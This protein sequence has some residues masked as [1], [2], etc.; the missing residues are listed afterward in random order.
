MQ[1]PVR[2]AQQLP[3]QENQVGL[4]CA[5]NV[6]GLGWL[7]DH[8]HRARGHFRFLAHA[9][10][11][12]G[13]VARAGRDLGIAG[14]AARRHIDQIHAKHT[15]ASGQLDGFVRVPA[16]FHPVGG[17]HPHE[18]W[19]LLRPDCTNRFDHLQ[20]QADAVLE[21]TA[22]FIL[23][24]IAQRRQELVQQVTV[25]GVHLDHFEARLQ[26]APGRGDKG[27]HYILDLRMGQLTGHSVLRIEGD[28]RRP[29]R[30]PA[31]LLQRDAAMLAQ[32]G[33]V[34]T[35]LAPGMG[36]LDTRNGPLGGDET[37]DALQ[38]G[39]LR[40]VPQAEVFSGDAPVCRD[41][42]G[43]GDDQARTADSAT[44][45]VHQ[46]PVVGQAIDRGILAHR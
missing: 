41:R 16:V 38:G 6:L 9:F 28:L 13:L 5:Q 23:T 24:L 17:R 2:V 7:G 36:E 30:L 45:Q 29:D 21:A 39:D 37:G 35:G 43:L 42:H 25:G 46:V 12:T 18:Q 15:Q 22:V 31:A 27:L 19:Q 8:A 32:P 26:R 4:A 10:G 1:R 44:A 11:K 3:G 40:V 14:R 20:G 33:A 34:G